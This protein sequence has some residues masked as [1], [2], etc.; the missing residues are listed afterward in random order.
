VAGWALALLI[1]Y[2]GLAF[3]VR[4][5]VAL[6]TTGSTGIANP[7]T[8]PPMEVLG[9]GL[10]I[11]ALVMGSATPPLVL[12][13]VLEPIDSLDTI[14]AHV[15]G[16]ALAAIGI[17][18]TFAAQ[19]A[20]GASWRI[21]VDTTE[22]TELVTGGVFALCRNPIYTFMVI[23]W[24]GLALLVPTWLSLASIAVG[25]LAFQV[26]VRL[27]EEPFL[28]ATQGEPYLDWARRV[29]RFV[30]GLGLLSR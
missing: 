24:T 23:A 19:M 17:V 26:Q 27:V 18:G 10:F 29:G 20:M 9:G 12:A 2:L 13:D 15:A 28:I 8:A 30:P 4:V 21:G 11:A 25:I 6:R 1:A 22:R 7:L 16:F 14:A 3:G 5:G